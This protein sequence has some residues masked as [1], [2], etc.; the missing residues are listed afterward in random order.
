MDNHFDLA[1]T[2]AT[3]IN[4]SSGQDPSKMPHRGIQFIYQSMHINSASNFRSRIPLIQSV[5]IPISQHQIACP[6]K[7]LTPHLASINETK[8]NKASHLGPII[9]FMCAETPK[10]TLYNK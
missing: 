6:N 7:F 10:Q 4:P 9:S 1:N 3:R 8:L 5:C 2:N